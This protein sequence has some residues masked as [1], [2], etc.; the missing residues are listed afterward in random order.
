M[1]LR[2]MKTG[3][4]LRTA[5]VVCTALV[6]A[7][8]ALSD[9]A[10]AS[11]RYRWVV[12]PLTPTLVEN[13]I[14][15]APRVFE[16]ERR[17]DARITGTTKD[18]ARRRYTSTQDA[19]RRL[20]E[21]CNL[22]TKIHHSFRSVSRSIYLADSLYVPHHNGARDEN[23]NDVEGEKTEARILAHNVIMIAPFKARLQR[24]YKE[25]KL[26]VSTK[27]PPDTEEED[28]NGI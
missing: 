23:G 5:L 16:A 14:K 28:A 18:D 25:Q 22:P 26:D 8:V 21:K 6:V 3:F 15:C 17:I 4:F 27:P 2:A 7:L 24:F 12:M 20:F 10:N 19:Q 9:V 11:Q 1:G 13:F